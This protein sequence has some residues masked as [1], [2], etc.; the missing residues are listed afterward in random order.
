[1][2]LTAGQ[3]PIFNQWLKN[4]M[5]DLIKGR[6]LPIAA[7]LLDF[8]G[9]VANTDEFHLVAW[10][11]ALSEYVIRID[12][13][14]Y[15]EHCVGRQHHEIASAIA[16]SNPAVPID[17]RRLIAAKEA[18]FEATCQ[19]MPVPLMPDIAAAI[20]LLISMHLTV[21]MVTGSSHKIVAQ[22][23]LHHK[24]LDCFSL[25][26]ASGDFKSPKP[27]PES[28]LLALNKLRIKGSSCLAFEDTHAGIAAANAAGIISCAVPQTFTNHQ[29]FFDRNLLLP[30]RANYIFVGKL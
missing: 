5:H 29:D 2:K 16:R 22:T 4:Q 1:M 24:I 21:G 11:N 28:Y 27:A 30:S 25:I 19:N 9:T 17:Q 12:R 14:F 3:M 10:N 15:S 18:S 23:L 8:D 7:V 13:H 26:I 6:A 20:D